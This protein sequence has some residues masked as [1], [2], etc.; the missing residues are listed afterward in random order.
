[1]EVD[2]LSKIIPGSAICSQI[3]FFLEKFIKLQRVVVGMNDDRQLLLHGLR[4]GWT[5]VRI[6]EGFHRR[7]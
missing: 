5:A 3:V 1:M 6:L 2:P 7:V 4:G